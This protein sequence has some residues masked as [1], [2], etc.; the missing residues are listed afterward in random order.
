[1]SGFKGNFGIELQERRHYFLSHLD[2]SAYFFFPER[3]PRIYELVYKNF[4]VFLGERLPPISSCA[5]RTRESAS[6]LTLKPFSIKIII[7]IRNRLCSRFLEAYAIYII[8]TD[9]SFYVSG[10]YTFPMHVKTRTLVAIRSCKQHWM[11]LSAMS[12]FKRI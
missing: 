10:V 12:S 8:T 6:Y 3:L 11:V 2:F 4:R 9:M 5:I 1:M 7:F